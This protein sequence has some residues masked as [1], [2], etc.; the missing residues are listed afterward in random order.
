MSPRDR[1]RPPRDQEVTPFGAILAR[2]CE[3]TQ[4]CGAALVDLQGET[5]DYAGRTDPYQIRICAAEMRLVLA[6]A[7]RCAALGWDA[8]H[9]LYLRGRRASFAAVPLTEGYALI[10]RL[11]VGSLQLSPRPIA[12]AVRELSREAGLR[13][14]QAWSA[15]RWVRVEVRLEPTGLQRPDA[16]WR[17]G[18]WRP[19]EI[20]GRFVPGI[21]GRRETGYRA[22]LI[23]GTDITLVREPLGRWYAD[24]L[25][26]V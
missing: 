9:Q 26:D 22:R 17:A 7:T 3:A 11:A 8:T 18:A 15:S 16:I 19:L 4:A 25:P 5:V 21:L 24:G 20:L 13:L 12:E 10:A 2:F 23:A 6:L 14:P 1:S